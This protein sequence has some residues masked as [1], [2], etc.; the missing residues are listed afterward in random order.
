[1]EESKW[2]FCYLVMK[3]TWLMEEDNERFSFFVVV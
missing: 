1:M 3:V 2:R